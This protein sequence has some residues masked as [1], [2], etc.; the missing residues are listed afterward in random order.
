M[1]E[2]LGYAGGLLSS[3]MLF[4]QIYKTFTTK[5][6]DDISY[7]FLYMSIISCI[8]WDSYA[9]IVV[10]RPLMFSS[11]VAFISNLALLYLKYKF[12][13]KVQINQ[14]NLED[15]NMDDIKEEIIV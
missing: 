10:D 9:F 3:S 15:S 5:K 8:L 4:P 1:I 14:N 13:T 11:S 2:L 6:A 7:Y 12:N